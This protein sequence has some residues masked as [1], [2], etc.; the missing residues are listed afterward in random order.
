MIELIVRPD[1]YGFE[2]LSGQMLADPFVVY[3]RLRRYDP[4]HWHEGLSAWLIASHSGCTAVLDASDIYVNDFRRVGEPERV[5]ELGVQTLDGL[6]HSDARH[7]ILS[8]MHKVDVRT[9]SN[10]CVSEIVERRCWPL[11][12][13]FDFISAV[14][15]PVTQRSI[16]GLFGI[17]WVED[18]AASYR[19]A[20]RA[21]VLG[22]DAGLEPTRLAPKLAA[23]AYVTE[24]L[25]PWI[26]SPPED[27]A[28][29]REVKRALS[30]ATGP[31]AANAIR[32]SV[33]MTFFAGIMSPG[34]TLACIWDTL[35]ATGLLDSAESL[36]LDRSSYAELVRHSGGVQVDARA[37]VQDTV[38]EGRSIRRGQIVLILT[39]SANRDEKVFD[40]AGELNLGRL[41]NPHLGF[42][43][44]EHSCVGAR[45]SQTLH[46]DLIN[47]LSS[48]F[49]FQRAGVPVPRP[50]GTLR[51]F[52]CL[53]TIALLR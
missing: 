21:L 46:I 48:R 7:A 45:I 25:E 35:L 18:D 10:K 6:E 49:R 50:S 36:V 24:L 5:E 11:G 27:S 41:H 43:R 16:V 20:L 29:L 14:A 4:V 19:A 47:S 42:G 13:P 28:V 53:P 37:C 30:L 39:A 52:D 23:R 3:E 15:D 34:S 38:L 33:R 17:P 31:A 44:G 8:A 2:P 12:E 40:G 1:R 9:W 22:M 32:N 26:A 51:G